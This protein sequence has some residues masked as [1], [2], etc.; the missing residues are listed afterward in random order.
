MIFK[1]TKEALGRAKSAAYSA[2]SHIYMG[3]WYRE[4]LGQAGTDPGALTVKLSGLLSELRAGKGLQPG[5][6]SPGKHSPISCADYSPA[7]KAEHKQ[8]RQ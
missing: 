8:K 1:S 7:T 5:S 2:P 6:P 3:L 4:K